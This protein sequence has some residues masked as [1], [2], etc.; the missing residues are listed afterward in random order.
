MK[1]T[2]CYFFLAILLF[3]CG[4]DTKTV[5]TNE[6]V[7]LNVIQQYNFR[8]EGEPQAADFTLPSE[9]SDANWGL[10][11]IMCQQAGYDLA[12]Y[13]GQTVSSLRYSLLEKYIGESLYLWVLTRDNVCACAYV[14]VRESGPIPGVFAVNNPGIQ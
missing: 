8:T 7:A 12:P 13:A 5:N 1:L 3:G 14:T 6:R 9:L 10:K 11:E 2:F 4:D